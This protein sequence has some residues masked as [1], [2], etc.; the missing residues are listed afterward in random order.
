MTCSK[1]STTSKSFWCH[2]FQLRTHFTPFLLFLLLTLSMYLFPAK[3]FSSCKIIRTLT[4]SWVNKTWLK[5]ILS[6]VL[7]TSPWSVQVQE[8]TDQKK[9]LT[10][11]LFTQFLRDLWK[12]FTWLY[13]PQHS[14]VKEKKTNTK[15]YSNH[16]CGNLPV[17]TISKAQ[18][19]WEK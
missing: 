16:K 4:T 2:Y 1:W 7:C 14:N 11:K 12:W 8:N 13:K 18:S 17:L 19:N 9:L 5:Y 10:L 6:D 15:Q 3:E